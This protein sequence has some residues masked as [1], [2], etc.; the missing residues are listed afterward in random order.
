[1]LY[2]KKESPPDFLIEWK[3]NFQRRYRRIAKYQDLNSTD[4]KSK[5][6]NTLIKEQKGLC[7]Y[8][9]SMI[10]YKL[11]HIEHLRPQHNNSDK[12]LAYDNL[13]V[14]CNGTD[15]TFTNHC[16]HKKDRWFEEKMVFPTDEEC[17]QFFD[18]DY[19]G[20]I[21]PSTKVSH[22]K[23]ANITI[24]KLNLDSVVLTK[25]RK[26][27]IEAVLYEEELTEEVIENLILIYQ[28]PDEEGN[29]V[30]FSMAILNIL[31]KEK[32]LLSAKAV[33]N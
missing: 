12:D 26:S 9:G 11:S 19:L 7:C 23:E 10:A 14:S 22:S 1:M 2:I 28:K 17:L 6:K 18:F 31:H 13:L 5:L 20:R 15:L 32:S 29:L 27:A 25:L 3:N 4:E 30:P 21:K 8:C 16:G 24:E 33:R